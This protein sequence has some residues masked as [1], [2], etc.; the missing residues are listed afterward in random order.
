MLK[1]ELMG[2]ACADGLLGEQL[3]AKR[4]TA[5][6]AARALQASVT[7]LGPGMLDAQVLQDVAVD[8]LEQYMGLVDPPWASKHGSADGSMLAA[9][10]AGSQAQASEEWQLPERAQKRLPCI[11]SCVAAVSEVV[12]ACQRVC[13][14]NSVVHTLAPRDGAQT[15]TAPMTTCPLSSC[16]WLALTLQVA[17]AGG[18][19]SAAACAE[20]LQPAVAAVLQDTASCQPP[21][22]STVGNGAAAAPVRP[23]QSNSAVLC[24]LYHALRACADA[25]AA[26]AAADYGSALQALN[27]LVPDVISMLAQLPQ[28][29][30]AIQQA[31]QLGGVDGPLQAYCADVAQAKQLQLWVLLVTQAVL[32]LPA[33]AAPLQQPQ[34]DH[35]ARFLLATA[36]H[37]SSA[38]SELQLQPG[39]EVSEQGAATAALVVLAAW[40]PPADGDAVATGDTLPAPAADGGVPGMR[41]LSSQ[42]AQLVVVLLQQPQ[43]PQHAERDAD[44]A[45]LRQRAIQLMRQ[46]AGS[47]TAAAWQV[48]LWLEPLALQQ[49]QA[50]AWVSVLHAPTQLAAIAMCHV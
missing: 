33:A 14:I 4:A 31:R 49:T 25:A 45:A 13:G 39:L 34:L 22:S 30:A 16:P 18:E 37:G 50:C 46:L 21:G 28:L 8:D 26:A 36:L 43:Q 27:A 41:A 2:P 23:L 32:R 5:A 12:A 3:A 10:G 17:A 11:A 6:A 35:A 44:V 19:S 48:L 40:P 20:V 38:D 24:V 15:N 29:L 47:N 42:I 7:A 9:R 1:A